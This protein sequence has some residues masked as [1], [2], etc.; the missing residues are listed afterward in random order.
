MITEIRLHNFKCFRD[1]RLPLK[2]G[3]NIL[4]GNN[5]AGKTTIL[6]AINLVLTGLYNNHPIIHDLSQYLFNFHAVD[7]YLKS[8]S[9]SSKLIPPSIEIELF[10]RN[11]AF[12][13]FMGDYNS[14]H[15]GKSCGVRLEIS[16]D[17]SFQEEYEILVENGL[18]TL[19]LEFYTVRWSGF[20][21]N[22]VF[23]KYLPL[24]SLLI[25]SSSSKSRNNTD[26]LLTRILKDNFD[27]S[28]VVGITQAFRELQETFKDNDVITS[29]NN[30]ISE[31][32][33]L[34]SKEVKLGVDMSSR[35][36]WEDYLTPYLDE[37]P[38]SYVGK[39]EQVMVKTQLSL[40]NKNARRAAIILLEE[41][42]SHLSHTHLNRLLKTISEK[43]SDKQLIVTTHSSFVA[44][45]LGLNNLILLNNKDHFELAS[46][47]SDTNRYF[48][49]LPGFD[50][51][52]LILCDASILVEGASDELIIQK[53]YMIMH[54][55]RLP[56]EDGID[57]ISINNLS[58]SR[59]LEISKELKLKTIVVTDN[60][61][62]IEA[63]ERK[64]KPFENCQEIDIC[65]DK[66][67]DTRTILEGESFNFNTME[68][69]FLRVNSMDSLNSVFNKN[70]SSESKLLKFMKENKVECALRI[71]ES[72][73]KNIIFPDYIIKAV[74]K[75]DK[76]KKE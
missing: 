36:A 1:F 21:R 2:G 18:S 55:G 12:P 62:D 48:K 3:L 6:E 63:L 39:G 65:Y 72:D 68:P 69:I 26:L 25:D 28:D 51:L 61:G 13:E 31:A 29:I 35:S 59:F 4:V 56:I 11:E 44:N 16:F 67:V 64:Y 15:D 60:D 43:C 19:P 50:T 41:P 73:C 14:R 52:R 76:G 22:H 17:E 74:C 58:F 38:F 71:F 20:A 10:F 47:E 7:E 37:I 46:L 33:D 49:K 5:E 40:A 70:F 27:D 32:C 30:K 66:Y 24:K 54:K 8:L 75:Y 45:K 53:A 42:E 9:T 23:P 34:S 57:V